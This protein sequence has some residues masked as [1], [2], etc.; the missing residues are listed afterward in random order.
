MRPAVWQNKDLGQA[1]AAERAA[2]P[3]QWPWDAEDAA[4][5][6][7]A[8][9]WHE[10]QR[11]R[12]IDLSTDPDRARQ[13]WNDYVSGEGQLWYQLASFKS[14]LLAYGLIRPE[15][16]QAVSHNYAEPEREEVK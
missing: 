8:L 10:G 11:D 4:R 3:A 12:L 6:K 1:I 13:V 2:H 15:D 16:A 9:A 5:R 14:I 7:L